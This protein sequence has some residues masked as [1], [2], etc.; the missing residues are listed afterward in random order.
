MPIFSSALDRTCTQLDEHADAAWAGIDFCGGSVLAGGELGLGLGLRSGLGVRIRGNLTL[1]LTLTLA[2]ALTLTQP[3]Q[4][5]PNQVLAGG[6]YGYRVPPS[7]LHAQAKEVGMP[8]SVTVTL[9]LAVNRNPNANPNRNR[10]RNRNPNRNRNRN[11]NRNPNLN[12]SQVPGTGG[13]ILDD[14]WALE[15]ASQKWSRW[16]P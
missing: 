6:E 13:V 14:V 2:L 16:E 3:K 15:L 10:N 12:H 11:R 4:P 7:C 1:A 5:N 9:T 8:L